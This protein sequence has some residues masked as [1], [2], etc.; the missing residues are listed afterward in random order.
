MHSM[1]NEYGQEMAPQ[2]VHLANTCRHGTHH[3]HDDSP[4]MK[5]FDVDALFETSETPAAANVTPARSPAPLGI[6][7]H[8]DNDVSK[9][10]DDLMNAATQSPTVA[11]TSSLS[12][13]RWTEKEDLIA[14]SAQKKLGNNWVKIA[15][16]LPDR[17]PQSVRN[18]WRR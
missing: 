17:T 10:A 18:R 1:S 8:W 11:E 3:S 7:S 15:T 13:Q 4:I 16:L 14:W 9:R 2:P 12:N 6:K 5:S